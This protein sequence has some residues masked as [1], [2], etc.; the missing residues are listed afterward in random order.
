M[1]E[2]TQYAKAANIEGMTPEEIEQVKLHLRRGRDAKLAELRK[3]HGEVVYTE[4][5]EQSADR[6]VHRIFVSEPESVEATC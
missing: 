5:I 6:I 2:P 3:E 1:S 4:Q